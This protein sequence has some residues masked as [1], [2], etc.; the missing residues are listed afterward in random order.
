[1]VLIYIQILKIFLKKGGGGGKTKLIHIH[2]I[3]FHISMFFLLQETSFFAAF[4]QF[5]QLKKCATMHFA[6]IGTM[7][8]TMHVNAFCNNATF[9][10]ILLFQVE[11]LGNSR[12]LFFLWLQSQLLFFFF[13]CIYLYFFQLL[14]YFVYLNFNVFFAFYPFF[15]FCVTPSSF[16]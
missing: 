5:F 13:F 9:L 2:T 15:S 11:V 10:I 12:F 14:I 4:L 3:V 8:A 7:R 1:M 16:S 6:Y